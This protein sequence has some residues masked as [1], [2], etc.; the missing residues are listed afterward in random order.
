MIWYSLCQFISHIILVTFLFIYFDILTVP[1]VCICGSSFYCVL[2]FLSILRYRR[3]V[4]FSA[5]TKFRFIQLFGFREE[6]IF[7]RNRPIGNYKLYLTAMF[8]NEQGR[9]EYSFQRTFQYQVLANFSKRF[10][11]SCLQGLCQ[12]ADR[13]EINNPYRGL[14][15]ETSYKVSVHL[16]ELFHRR[17]IL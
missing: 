13:N 3:R 1:R 14:L 4:C 7:F 15:I 17:I 6:D 9:I 8:F 11:K 2:Y 12:L 10:Q 16:P 5:S